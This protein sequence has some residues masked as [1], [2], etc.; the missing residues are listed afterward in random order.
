MK[1]LLFLFAITLTLSA[2]AQG[3]KYNGRYVGVVQDVI[4]VGYKVGVDAAFEIPYSEIDTSNIVRLNL[5]VSSAKRPCALNTYSYRI[6]CGH[7]SYK[8]DPTFTSAIISA[9]GIVGNTA[10]YRVIYKREKCSVCG[11]MK[12]YQKLY[13]GQFKN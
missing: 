10:Y 13:E 11:Q 12:N 7:N 6:I 2:S 9:D 4:S 5:H 3:D 1:Q 8:P